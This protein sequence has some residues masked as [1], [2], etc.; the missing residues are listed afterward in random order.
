MTTCDQAAQQDVIVPHLC[1]ILSAR[2][3]AGAF[4]LLEDSAIAAPLAMPAVFKG[5]A[6]FDQLVARGE[7]WKTLPIGERTAAIG[8]ALVGTPYKGFTLEIDDHIE[9][10]S[11]N[12]NAFDCW[13]FFESA[14][15]FARMLDEPREQWTPETMLKFIE[16]D[17]YRGGQCD[18]TY[19]SC[20]YRY[21]KHK[22]QLEF[23][24]PELSNDRHL[25]RRRLRR[26]LELLLGWRNA[27]RSGEQLES[28]ASLSGR[29]S[30]IQG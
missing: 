29:A 11:V 4:V 30:R 12:L 28:P 3:F 6:K 7:T 24:S 14:L 16:L 26:R 8:R 20:R 19:L 1:R 23:G 9:A 25:C 17:R 15:A 22:R 13:T 5:R 27:R 10:P 2:L 21:S 18:G